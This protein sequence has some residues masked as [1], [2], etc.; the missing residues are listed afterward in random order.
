MKTLPAEDGGDGS[1]SSWRP[2]FTPVIN[3]GHILQAVA[4]IITVGGGAVACY[5]SL[6]G[7]IEGQRSDLRA[8]I[9]GFEIRIETQRAEL[10]IA[11][12]GFETRLN[13]AEHAIAE[14]QAEERDFAAEMR[15]ALTKIS[16][17]LSE[18]R[19]QVVRPRPAR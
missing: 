1:G 10:R 7:D 4:L 17:Q 9:A 18:L 12:A 3:L 14:R 16:D 15:A 11:M 8:A 5:V 6:R 13:V 19:V 2:R